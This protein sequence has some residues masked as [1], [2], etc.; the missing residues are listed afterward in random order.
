MLQTY[1]FFLKNK[2]ARFINLHHNFLD[3]FLGREVFIKIAIL[4]NFIAIFSYKVAKNHYKVVVFSYYIVV[5][6]YKIA[7]FS[8][9]DFCI[10]SWNQEY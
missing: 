1:M 3:K 7:K 5:F 10:E 4:D 8:Y 6:C 2:Q 9:F